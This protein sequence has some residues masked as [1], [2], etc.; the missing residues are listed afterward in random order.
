MFMPMM[1][2]FIH[3]SQSMYMMRLSPGWDAMGFC[4]SRACSCRCND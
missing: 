4:N 1:I 2:I 3:V